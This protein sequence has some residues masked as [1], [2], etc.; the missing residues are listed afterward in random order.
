M[1]FETPRAEIEKFD[2]DDIISTSG[3]DEESYPGSY[4]AWLG[5]PCEGRASDDGDPEPCILPHD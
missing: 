5:N 3:G 2:L 1:K 4:A